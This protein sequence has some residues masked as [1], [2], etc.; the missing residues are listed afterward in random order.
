MKIQTTYERLFCYLLSYFLHAVIKTSFGFV[1]EKTNPLI[2][3]IYEKVN[4]RGGLCAIAHA[5]AKSRT[6]DLRS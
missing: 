4:S 6:T 2:Y 5:G 3:I 1:L